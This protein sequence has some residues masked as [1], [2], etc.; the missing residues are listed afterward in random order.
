M[1]RAW[2]KKDERQ[3]EHIQESATARGKPLKVAKEIAAR[4]V[5]KQRRIEGRT[6]NRETQGTGHPHHSLEE[7][8]KKELENRA[9]QLGIRGRS[10]MSKSELIAAIRAA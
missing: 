9:A 10:R 3:F 2:T 6:P 5:N 4:T 7:R 1:P 8:T